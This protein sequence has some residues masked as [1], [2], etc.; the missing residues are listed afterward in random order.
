MREKISPNM[1][2]P[3]GSGQKYKKCCQPYHRGKKAESAERL[4]RTRYS[5][6]AA[7]EPDY[8]IRTTDCESEIFQEDQ[9]VWREELRDFVSKTKFE[10][11]EILEREEGETEAVIRFKAYYNGG[12]HNERSLFRKKEERWYYTGAIS[13]SFP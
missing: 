7:N 2:C 6:F 13:V 5:A 8:L 1:K 12:I 3:C 4:M 11:L 9:K 10:K